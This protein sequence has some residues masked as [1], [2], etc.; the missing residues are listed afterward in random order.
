LAL[1]PRYADPGA[2]LEYFC[3]A[4]KLCRTFAMLLDTLNRHRG[5]GQQRIV[6]EHELALWAGDNL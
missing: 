2:K 5:K 3:Q 4:G 6:V 1:V